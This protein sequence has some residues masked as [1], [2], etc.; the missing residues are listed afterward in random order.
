MFRPE[1]LLI[2]VVC[3][4]IA[5]TAWGHDPFEVT[6]LVFL[7][8]NRIELQATFARRAAMILAGQKDAPSGVWSGPQEFNAVRPLLVSSAPKLFSIIV[9]GQPMEA[10]EADVLQGVEDHVEYRLTYALP[11]RG[12]LTI[13][14]IFL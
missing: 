8:T 5:S 12:P 10:K 14:A 13:G 7:Q 4:S 1:S 2:G 9:G 3:F 11:A 6:T